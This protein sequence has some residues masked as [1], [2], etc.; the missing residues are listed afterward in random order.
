ML[1]ILLLLT[2]CSAGYCVCVINSDICKKNC[3]I[4][5]QNCIN[6]CTNDATYCGISIQSG[7]YDFYVNGEQQ[8]GYIEIN[9]KQN[10]EIYG[11]SNKSTIIIIHGLHGIFSAYNSQQLTIRNIVFDFYRYPF[12]YGQ[13]IDIN[14]TSNQF[15]LKID[16]NMYPFPPNKILDDGQNYSFTN[17]IASFLGYDSLNQH[18]NYPDIYTN[19]PDNM[20]TIKSDTNNEQIV[21][22]LDKNQGG[23]NQIELNS[24]LILRHGDKYTAFVVTKSTDFVLQ[25]VTLYTAPGMAFFSAQT[26]NIRLTRVEFKK[27][28]NRPMSTLAD[29]AHLVSNTGDII[30]ENSLFNGQGDD[31]L[32]ILNEFFQIDKIISDNSLMIE[33]DGLY[34]NIIGSIII[35][36]IYQFRNR[37]TLQPYFSSKCINITYSE[38]IGNI[39]TFEDK[40]PMNLLTIYDVITDITSLPT[41]VILRNN[42]YSQNRARGTLLKVSN[43]SFINN[44]YIDI[45]GP[46]ILIRPESAYWLES[47]VSH[48]MFINENYFKNCNYGPAQMNGTIMITATICGWDN[49]TNGTIPNKNEYYLNIGQVHQNFTITNNIM[50]QSFDTT[51]INRAAISIRAVNDFK[52][53]NNTFIIPAENYTVLQKFNDDGIQQFNNNRC[54]MNIKSFTCVVA[55]N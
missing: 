15:T 23:I 24:N 2:L 11:A 6:N 50:N 34:K 44:T 16:P 7:T 9:E 10:I 3:L 49:T 46:A 4:E 18:P 41:K 30:I 33:R 42:I 8:G 51:Q 47:T 52:V 19:A 29:S 22:C 5:L 38:S 25:D 12:T 48:N 13:V 17:S 21:I 14:Q 20:V 54:K 31:G 37:K 39:M 45:T 35:G 32:N 40:L 53:D 28:I 27:N 55:N 36:D 26:K 43:V 1:F